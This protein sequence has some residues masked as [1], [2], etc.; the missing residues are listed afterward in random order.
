MK[1]LGN[2]INK[3]KDKVRKGAKVGAFAGLSALASGCVSTIPTPNVIVCSYEEDLDNNGLD[4]PKDYKKIGNN[5]NS[6]ERITIQYTKA[7]PHSRITIKTYNENKEE[8]C[9]GTVVMGENQGAP[10]FTWPEYSFERGVY[11]VRI[12]SDDV[13]VQTAY[14]SV[15]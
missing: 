2:L 12:F 8:V 11:E 1:N 5:F 13:Q 10:L 7:K 14:F 4:Y 3:T 9:N 6:N 15:Q